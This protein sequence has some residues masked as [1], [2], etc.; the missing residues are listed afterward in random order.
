MTALSF[1]FA[2]VLML[3]VLIFVHELGHFLVAKLCGVRVL[4]FSLGFG[5]PIGIGRF[6]LAFQRGE[7]EY[8]AAWFPLGG[9]VKMLGESPDE[10][11]EALEHPERSEGGLRA[12][13]RGEAEP[14]RSE[15]GLRARGRGEAEPERAFNRKPVWQRLLILCAGPGMN[16]LLP[17]VIFVAVLAVGMPR[18]DP[19]IGT[20]EPAS[21][22][23]RAGL[24][25]G[26]RV[27]AVSGQPVRWWDDVEEAIRAHAG[28]SVVLRIA[29]DGADRDI[30]LAVEG[31]PGLDPYGTRTQ[32][33]WA[34]LGHSRLAAVVGIPAAGSPAAAAGL[35]SGDRVVSVDGAPV[36][37]WDGFVQRYA[38]TREGALRVEVEREAAPGAQAQKLALELPALGSVDA[39][40]VVPATV[41]VAQISPASPAERAGLHPGD[42]IVSVDGSPVGSFASFSERVRSS[43]GHPLAIA[44]ARGGQTRE[45]RIKPELVDADTGLGIPE[46]RYLIGITAQATTVA[47]ALGV[48]QEV[49]PLRALPRAVAM[50]AEVTKSFIQGL[51]RL[52]TGEVSR[53]QLAGPIGIAEIAHSAFERGWQAYLSTLVLISVNLAVLNLLPIPVLDGGQAVL[54]LIEGV[55][56]SPVSVRTREIAQQ[57]GV[58]LLVM[59]MALAFWNDL[60]RHW[61]RFVDWVRQS[62]GL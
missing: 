18:P 48:D 51:E 47:G 13:G 27:L 43:G 15:G 19:V 14:E 44:Y 62:T 3:G 8:V 22:A 46:E 28:Q 9:Y 58:T 29:R 54:I 24:R 55:K 7:T 6:R 2:F 39:L 53:K 49:N 59:L 16:L 5:P 45:L 34:G 30:A 17:V 35:R 31:R 4:R 25:V 26:D 10:E 52:A 36:A 40:G 41:L 12:G 33:G 11:A 38:A 37:D 57:I 21:P 60:S 61:E 1:V 50:T 20:V 32:V 23:A 42:L 56:R